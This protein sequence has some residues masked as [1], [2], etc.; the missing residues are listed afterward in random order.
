[1]LDFAVHDQPALIAVC[2][3][4]VVLNKDALVQSDDVSLVHHVQGSLCDSDLV[5]D[6]DH[7]VNGF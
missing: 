3:R 1:M 5:H 6:L 4:I 7:F 2:P